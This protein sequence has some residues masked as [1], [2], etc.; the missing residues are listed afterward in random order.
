MLDCSTIPAG[1][2]KCT[3]CGAVLPATPEYFYRAKDER[4]SVTGACKSCTKK[5]RRAYYEA[6]RERVLE[7]NRRWRKKN[8]DRIRE[9]NRKYQAEHREQYREYQRQWYWRN[10]ERGRKSAKKWRQ[11]NP[12]KRRVTIRRWHEQNPERNRFYAHRRIARKNNA[13]GSHTVDDI[14]QQYKKQEGKCYWC[15]TAVADTYHIDHV[16][17]LSRGGSNSPDN[18]VISCPTCNLSKG[19]KLPSE[20]S[21][22]NGKS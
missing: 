21:G 5:Y 2:K 6:N 9:I 3:K 8:K 1:Y 19:S 18:L 13:I 4:Y 16:I 22:S 14:K 20:W 17:P 11:N 7:T 10:P 12:E 15:N